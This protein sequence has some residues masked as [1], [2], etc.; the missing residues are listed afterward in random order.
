MYLRNILLR[1]NLEKKTELFCFL[2][3]VNFASVS[4][5]VKCSS[6]DCGTPKLPSNSYLIS[7][8][9]L[10]QKFDWMAHFFTIKLN[11]EQKQANT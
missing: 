1:F 4:G 7:I 9:N 8:P 10:K 5:S 2:A 11:C 6:Q 3:M